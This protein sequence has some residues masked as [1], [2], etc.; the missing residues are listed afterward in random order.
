MRVVPLAVALIASCVAC[1]NEG[2]N[3]VSHSIPDAALSFDAWRAA[4][5]AERLE[6][7][8][9]ACAAA[10]GGFSVRM[11]MDSP[12]AVH[13][14]TGLTFVLIPAVRQE[15]A[16]D[17]SRYDE[18]PF[19]MCRRTTLP[20]LP[21]GT[22]AD[23][24]REVS[25]EAAERWCA[26]VGLD[27]PTDHQVLR[28]SGIPRSIL[29]GSDVEAVKGAAARER[30]DGHVR[31]EP[32]DFG[33]EGLLTDLPQLIDYEETWAE[34]KGFVHERSRR[35][36]TEAA[37]GGAAV[38]GPREILDLYTYRADGHWARPV[39]IRPCKVPTWH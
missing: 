36:G 7:L 32:S 35:R 8:R 14:R 4:P 5:K 20:P 12:E 3:H 10:G 9:Q 22:E 37:F 30:A 15:V 34:R 33:V 19:L 6:A 25:L 2:E 13:E 21:G 27:L 17:P 11:T 18:V 16:R 39:A 31:G 38:G 29:D 1:S 28:A 26:E 23:S 24:D